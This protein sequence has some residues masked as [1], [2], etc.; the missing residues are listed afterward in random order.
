MSTGDV[1]PHEELLLLAAF[2][3][4]SGRRQ[5]E[6]TR[7]YAVY[8]LVEGARRALLIVGE[9]DPRLEPVLTRLDE[10]VHA[11]PGSTELGPL[12]DDLC[13]RMADVLQPAEPP[14]RP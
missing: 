10:V 2:L 8:R 12:L 7:D 11:P 1:D 6:E 3:L 5:T 9:T 14:T 4:S 13:A